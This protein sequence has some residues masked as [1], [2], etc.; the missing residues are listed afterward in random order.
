MKKALILITCLFATSANAALVSFTDRSA[1][2]AAAGATSIED[3]D[4]FT[5]DTQF[6]T[7][8]LDVGDFS[9][10]MTSTPSTN[11]NIIDV[12]PLANAES[13]VNGSANMRVFTN[14]NLG[15]DLMFMFDTAIS[16]FG[17][18]FRS[19]NDEIA[20]TEIVVGG[21]VLTL[22]IA[23]G[24]GQASF[25]GFTSDTAF[26]SVI[27]RGIVNDVYGIDNVTYGSATAVSAPSTL[28]MMLLGVAGFV[29][30]RRKQA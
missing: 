3:F 26:T 27:F 20:R 10:S 18:D 17:A 11:F 14:G 29:V 28:A 15:V 6:H 8:T 22:P 16:S 23:S 9:L 13:D 7:G 1:F 30:A 19:L 21:E 12:P 4:S 2:D 25:Y 24:S 5:I